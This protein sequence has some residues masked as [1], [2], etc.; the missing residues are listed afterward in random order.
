[1]FYALFLNYTHFDMEKGNDKKEVLE[2]R[3]YFILLGFSSFLRFTPC[4]SRCLFTL[5][6][7]ES[8]CMLGFYDKF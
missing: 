8:E 6:L 1:M 5:K 2:M 7:L 4:D 3:L